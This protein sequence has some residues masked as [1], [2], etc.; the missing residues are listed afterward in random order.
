MLPSL[1]SRTNNPQLP[2]PDKPFSEGIIEGCEEIV[3][4]NIGVFL[5]VR[6]FPCLSLLYF[7][8][9]I[10]LIIYFNV[11]HDVVRFISYCSFDLLCVQ[12]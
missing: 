5:E 3:V 7:K 10:G 6:F 4:A 12:S 9:L 1:I 11:F 8:G 2:S